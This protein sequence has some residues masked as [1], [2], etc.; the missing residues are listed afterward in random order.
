[1]KKLSAIF[2]ASVLVITL[3]ASAGLSSEN[4]STAEKDYD[5]VTLA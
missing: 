5:S 4:R 1:M 3:A 2:F